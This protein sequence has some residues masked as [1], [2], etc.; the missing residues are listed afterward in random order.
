[1]DTGKIMLG[2][3]LVVDKHLCQ[4]IVEILPVS[5]CYPNWDKLGPSGSYWLVCRYALLALLLEIF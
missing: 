2:V 4:G 3:I 5:T 1:M